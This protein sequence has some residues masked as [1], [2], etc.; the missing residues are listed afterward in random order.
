[1]VDYTRPGSYVARAYCINS[2]GLSTS[3]QFRVIING[4]AKEGSN[5]ILYAIIGIISGLLLSLI[6]FIIAYF[7]YKKRHKAI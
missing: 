3:K 6:G 2:S 5:G 7:I 4:G 1:M